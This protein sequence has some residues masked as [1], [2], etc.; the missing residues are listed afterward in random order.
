VGSDNEG[1]DKRALFLWAMGGERGASRVEGA[2]LAPCVSVELWE[3][4][5]K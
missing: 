1:I 5:A 4:G 3:K 2:M